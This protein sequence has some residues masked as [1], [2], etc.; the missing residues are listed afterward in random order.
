MPVDVDVASPLSPAAANPPYTT[1]PPPLHLPLAAADASTFRRLF[2]T[3]KA[4]LT[5]YKTGLKYI[6]IN[7]RMLYRD[8]PGPP[9]A[10][11][12]APNKSRAA[13]VVKQKQKQQQQQQQQQEQQ[14]AVAVPP[15]ET[16]AYRLLAARTA[17]DLRR[18]PLFGL[19]LLVCGEV[20]AAGGA[21]A[22][23]AS[24]R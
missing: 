11:A 21:G 4:Y 9:A 18:L 19:L 13:G 7:A 5:F 15:R 6:Y 1:R 10:A 12:T 3:G 24:C 22:A 8:A 14:Q 23:G 20:H 17:H 2:D 16:R